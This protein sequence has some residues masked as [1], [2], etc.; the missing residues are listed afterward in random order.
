MKKSITH[1]LLFLLLPALL[2]AQTVT[3]KVIN[4][5]GVGNVNFVFYNPGS[6]HPVGA[7]VFFP[8][9]DETGTDASKLYTNGSLKFEKAGWHPPYWIVGV[10]TPYSYGT[11]N[12]A[13]ALP[14]VRGA[15]REITSGRY[16]IDNTKIILTGLSYG[17]DHIVN[18]MQHEPDSTFIQPA[19]A[20]LMSISM[21]G[22]S[23]SYPNDA[24]AGSD[25]RF[26]KIPLWGF[27]GTSD[28][29]YPMMS[30]FFSLTAKAGYMDIFTSAA[31]GHNGT[32]WNTYYNPSWQSNGTNIY[33]WAM[34]YQASTPAAAPVVKARI[35]LDSASIHYP[36]S[37]VLFTDSSLNAYY[38]T[39]S[40]I[41][42]VRYSP[43]ADKQILLAN[44]S[45]G[46]YTV[47]LTAFDSAGHSD[48]ARANIVVYGPPA[49]PSCPSCP[50]Q[51]INIIPTL[52][53]NTW[54]LKLVYKDGTT[55]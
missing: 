39:L 3:T 55:Q 2:M 15:L 24:L 4:L 37:S 6:L 47:T 43:M 22:Q 18:Y 27:C 49:C 12:N 9:S 31:G 44:L 14:F 41:P 26:A 30:H 35:L 20:I 53:G 10:Q 42:A 28:P 51:V 33:D 19:A 52:I 8:G 34:K 11:F 45:A 32:F 1:L 21:Y 50:G 40:V 23:G 38:T 29:F 5:P 54:Q 48:T 16:A 36:G 46:S 25:S 17:A 7:V 13:L